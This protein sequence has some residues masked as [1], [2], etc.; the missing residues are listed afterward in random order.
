MKLRRGAIAAVTAPVAALAI[1]SP[2]LASPLPCHPRVLA[3][4]GG[5][6][7][8]SVALCGF[9]TEIYH[10]RAITVTVTSDPSGGVFAA[11]DLNCGNGHQH[12][13]TEGSLTAGTP[14]RFALPLPV[15]H[16]TVCEFGAAAHTDGTD[17]EI[18]VKAV[19]SY[20][21]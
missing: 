18:H 15:A 1:A 9:R 20:M 21:G 8:F 5:A 3:C 11:W 10:P 19:I 6:D 17:S 13:E 4:T 12:K 2:A 7:P 16:P 14:L